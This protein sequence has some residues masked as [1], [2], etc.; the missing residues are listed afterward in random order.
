V[1]EWCCCRSGNAGPWFDTVL[2]S[3]VV[4][5]SH[6]RLSPSYL[7]VSSICLIFMSITASQA[8]VAS[9]FPCIATSMKSLT[10]STTPPAGLRNNSLTVLQQMHPSSHSVSASRTWFGQPSEPSPGEA[11]ERMNLLASLMTDPSFPM[12]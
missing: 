8:T 3:T 4:G 9:K 12:F 7:R 2:Y 6:R 1:S 10:Q 5:L 11:N